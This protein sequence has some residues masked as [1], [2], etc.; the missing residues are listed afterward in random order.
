MDKFVKV[1]A[2][3]SANMKMIESRYGLDGSAIALKICQMAKSEENNCKW[4]EDKMKKFLSDYGISERRINL[5]RQ[6][7]NYCAELGVI[8][9]ELYKKNIISV[10]DEKGI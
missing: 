1:Q 8:S 3:T 9:K 7:V 4:N 2:K 6:V 5:V 10:D